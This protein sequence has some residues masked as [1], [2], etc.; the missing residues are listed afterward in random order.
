MVKHFN[1]TCT[2]F[3]NSTVV[4]E[5]L[6]AVV[7]NINNELQ[8]SADSLKHDSNFLTMVGETSGK[9][10]SSP[11]ILLKDNFSQI[12]TKIQTKQTRLFPDLA[13]L[14]SNKYNK[15]LV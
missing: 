7:F 11:T 9:Y 5:N 14:P 15:E 2:P 10:F 4:S 13:M 8:M 6:T 1:W 12:L 3:L